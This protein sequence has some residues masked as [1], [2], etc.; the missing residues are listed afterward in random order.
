MSVISPVVGTSGWSGPKAIS[1]APADPDCAVMVRAAAFAL[2][3]STSVAVASPV[4]RYE[5]TAARPK[6]ITTD[7]FHGVRSKRY[8]RKALERIDELSGYEAGWS[9]PDSVGPMLQTVIQAKDF[10]QALLENEG[11]AVPHISLASD[12][13]INLYWKSESLVMDLGFSGNGRYSYF[14]EF[15]NGQEFIEDGAE[16]NQPLP[17]ELLAA[18]RA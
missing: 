3:L 9:G 5:D 15:A 2:C 18:L 17:D 16:L 11:I 4:T 6:L 14:A 8:A 1:A 7:A 13:E 10:T 12:G